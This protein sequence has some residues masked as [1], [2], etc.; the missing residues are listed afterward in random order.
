LVNFN[1]AD[2]WKSFNHPPLKGPQLVGGVVEQA[3]RALSNFQYVRCGREITSSQISRRVL[4]L[5]VPPWATPAQ[6]QAL[7][8]FVEYGR[9]QNPPVTVKIVEM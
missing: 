8:Q 4:E 6:R 5:V 3:Y 9:I 1:T 2:L 7:Q